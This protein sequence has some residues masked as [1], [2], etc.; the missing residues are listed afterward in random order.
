MEAG[1]LSVLS[2]ISGHRFIP[3]ALGKRACG[4]RCAE[5]NGTLQIRE[6]QLSAVASLDPWVEFPVVP[7]AMCARVC[8]HLP[9][10]VR[11]WHPMSV[12][13]TDSTCAGNVGPG[14]I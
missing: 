8:V 4:N 7:A 11:V 12:I 2:Q 5:I 9:F 13:V 1:P 10:R 14:Y 6:A 3:R